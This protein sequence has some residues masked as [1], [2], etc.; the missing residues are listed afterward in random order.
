MD[1]PV[2]IHIPENPGTHADPNGYAEE[3]D[4]FPKQNTLDF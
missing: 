1:A 3:T 4:S 2:S